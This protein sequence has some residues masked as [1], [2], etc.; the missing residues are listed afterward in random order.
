MAVSHGADFVVAQ[1]LPESE[2]ADLCR[3]TPIPVYAL[4]PGGAHA[5]DRLRRLGV[6]GLAV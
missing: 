6:H 1:D 5:L 2:L 4:D 3:A